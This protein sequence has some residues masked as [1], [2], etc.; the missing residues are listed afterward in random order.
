LRPFIAPYGVEFWAIF[1]TIGSI[2]AGRFRHPEEFTPPDLLF[3]LIVRSAALLWGEIDPLSP[4]M[5]YYNRRHIG[6]LALQ[7]SFTSF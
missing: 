1:S 3:F 2:P 5:A 4:A 6:D 7:I